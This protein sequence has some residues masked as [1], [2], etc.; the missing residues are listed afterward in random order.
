MAEHKPR[1]RIL[2]LNGGGVRGLYTISVLAEFERIL[3]DGDESYSIA[4]HFDLIAGTSIGGLLAIGL[5]DGKTARELKTKVLEHA[6]TIF[7]PRKSLFPKVLWDIWKG[8]RAILRNRYNGENIGKAVVDIV[9][10]DRTIRD[11]QRR[12]LIPTVNITT[13][14]P[15]FV[16][17]CHNPRFTR[18][19]R[20][21]LVDVARATSAAPTYFEPHYIEELE[22]YFVDGGLV[23][24][25]PSYVAYHEAITD[26]KEE[27]EVNSDSQVY[28]LNIGTMASDFCINPERIHKM[29]SGYFRLWGLG[30]TLVET[31]MTGNQWM[32]RK[33]A[34]RALSDMNYVSLD[35]TVPDQQASIITLDNSRP[36][37]LKVLVARGIQQATESLANSQFDLKGKFFNGKADKFIH[38]KDK[39]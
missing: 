7:P 37:A 25:N 29:F 27:F 34:S 26:L 17:T 8:I 18:D 22:A 10:S 38:P 30:S 6:T 4:E 20:L 39:E 28:V 16:K 32:H 3:A 15:L 35:D 14:K 36:E 11:L 24:N 23:A 2:S 1:I 9:G 33:M 12:V 13:G 31:V 21:K 19:D 5:A